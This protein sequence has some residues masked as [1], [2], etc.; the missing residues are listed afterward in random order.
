MAYVYRHIRL[1]KNEPFY[2]GVGQDSPS[3]IGKYK[4]AYDKNR[5][6]FW[7][8]IVNRTKYEVEIL[9]DDIS[10]EKAL[11]KEI[12]FIALYG[13]KNKGKGT[14]CNLT[15]GGEG[16]KGAIPKNK[17][18]VVR[19]DFNNN[20][21]KIYPSIK[22]VKKDGF[23]PACVIACCLKQIK[24]HKGFIWQYFDQL[25]D[26]LS[27]NKSPNPERPK[28]AIIQKDKNNNVIK[29]W[30][31]LTEAKKIGKFSASQIRNCCNKIS[32]FHKGYIWEFIDSSLIT[33]SPKKKYRDYIRIVQINPLNNLVI[34]I[35]DHAN[36]ATSLGF[37]PRHI[38]RCCKGYAN[39]HLGYKWEYFD[40]NK[41]YE[42]DC[43]NEIKPIGKN[44]KGKVVQKN[45]KTGEI[46]NIYESVKNAEKD[47]FGQ[48]AIYACIRGV[49]QHY[50]GYKW[51]Y[52]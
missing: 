4:R 6:S 26:D 49:Y 19:K 35:W 8:R 23:L 29:I 51:E 52:F 33:E 47:G 3:E 32:R 48:S 24:K 1:D 36:Q 14:L 20:V 21:I 43:N 31:S 12:E 22:S 11:E 46:V 50:K 25:S 7:G 30:D 17:R 9:I 41:N 13:R 34:K 45:F 15:D 2:I 16:V 39:F 40:E 27:Y 44:K 37:Q 10:Y 28:K 42:F 5:N 18:K 38:G